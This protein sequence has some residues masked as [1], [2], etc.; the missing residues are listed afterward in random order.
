MRHRRIKVVALP[1]N[2]LQRI[3]R[4][5]VKQLV[6]GLPVVVIQRHDTMPRTIAMS[7]PMG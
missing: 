5:V 3:I 7:M 4:R 1:R 2:R 6:Q